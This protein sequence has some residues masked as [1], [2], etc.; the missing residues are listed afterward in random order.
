MTGAEKDGVIIQQIPAP[1]TKCLPGQEVAL[2]VAASRGTR[3]AD[4]SL[5][6]DFIGMSNRQVNSL[7]ARLGVQVIIKGVG[8]AVRQSQPPGRTI[9]GNPITIKMEKSWR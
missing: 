3:G 4:S 8:Y 7:A 9:G 2:A 1:G 5:C 6:P